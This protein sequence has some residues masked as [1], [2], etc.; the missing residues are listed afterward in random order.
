M[1]LVS[2]LFL[3]NIFNIKLKIAKYGIFQKRKSHFGHKMSRM[4]HG[5]CRARKNVAS[6]DKGPY[7]EKTKLQLLINY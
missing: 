7:K 3:L 1:K 2:D 4:W 5:I 6:Y